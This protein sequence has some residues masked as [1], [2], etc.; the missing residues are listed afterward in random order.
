MARIAGILSFLVIL[1]AFTVSIARERP[2]WLRHSPCHDRSK[3]P[4]C[5]KTRHSRALRPYS[6]KTYRNHGSSDRLTSAGHRAR[7]FYL[8][9]YYLRKVSVEA[10]AKLMSRAHMNTVVIDVKDDLGRVLYPSKVPLSRG[11]QQRLL[12]DPRDIV[13]RFHRRGIYV[14]ARLVCFKDSRLPYKRPDLAVRAASRGERLF[15]A[16]A[17]WIDAYS[18][19]VQDYLIDLAR[20]VRGLGFDEIQ[21]DY[22]RFPKGRASRWGVWLHSDGR[23]RAEVIN[24]FLSR[25]DRAVDLPLSADVYGLTTLVEGDPRKLGQTIEQMAAHVEAIS[26]MMYANGMGTYFP[27]GVLTERVYRILHCGLWR[28]RQKAPNIVLRPFL[29]SYPNRV[30]PF[31]GPGFI[32]SQVRIAERSGAEGFLFWNS[33]MQNTVAYR[34]LRAMGQRYFDAFGTDTNQHREPRNGPGPWCP[35]NGVVW[36][37]SKKEQASLR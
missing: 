3:L 30:E 37:E 28:A 5:L 27:G 10:I 35:P 23:S 1:L 21:L 2:A 20:E 36:E 8:S 12:R 4:G 9:P 25:L 29:Q 26:P 6:Q 33:T 24:Q 32:Q 17:N 7:G 16:G 22:I 34:A 31:F 14:I 19:E 15:S 13:R 18:P 11:S